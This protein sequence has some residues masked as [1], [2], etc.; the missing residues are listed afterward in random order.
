MKERTVGIREL[1]SSLSSCLKRVKGG[2]ALVIT[3]RGKPI[4][5]IYPIEKSLQ[6]QLDEGRRA[7]KWSWKG[8]KWQPAPPRVKLRGKTLMSDLLLEDRE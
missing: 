5:R 4:G 6:E 3:E 2:E 1:K 7:G 8:R